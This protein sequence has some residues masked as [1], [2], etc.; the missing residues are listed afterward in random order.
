MNDGPIN[1]SEAFVLELYQKSILSPWCYRN[2]K[3]QDGDDLSD[4]L[5]VCDPHFPAPHT[6]IKR[7]LT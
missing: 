5:V 6:S 4:I 3:G 2:P 1:A 7:W